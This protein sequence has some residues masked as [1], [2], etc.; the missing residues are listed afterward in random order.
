ELARDWAAAYDAVAGMMIEAADA[1]AG[2]P[3]WWELD[4][5]RVEPR[6]PGIAV[7]TVVPREPLP[8]RAGQSIAVEAPTRPRMWRPLTPA[9]LPAADGSF[10]LHV[11]LVPGGQV[12]P[13]LVQAVEPG[14]VLR[15]GAPVGHRLT[16]RA[17]GR[18]GLLLVAGGTG[19]APMKALVEQLR[20]E[21]AGRPTH[22]VW[23]CA[24]RPT[25]TT[26]RRC[27]SWPQG[28]RGW[29]SCRASRTRRGRAAASKPAR[30]WTWRCGAA[31]GRTT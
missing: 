13:T 29:T 26:C 3:A 6:A 11:R 23:G 5:V 16:L 2:S 31:R 10:E 21:G 15:A 30:R 9:T 7:L 20:A 22:L 1:A 14:D 12:S 28:V 8:Y 19:L 18:G 27:G 4:V 25:C 24:G 17:G